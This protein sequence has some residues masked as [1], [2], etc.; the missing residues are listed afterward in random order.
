[1]AIDLNNPDTYQIQDFGGGNTLYRDTSTGQFYDPSDPT[2]PLSTSDVQQYGAPVSIGGA[3]APAGGTASSQSQFGAPAPSTTANS[4]GSGG[5]NLSGMS[6]MFTAIGSAFANM[7]NPPKT[8]PGGQPLVYDSI[9]GT[10]IPASAAG[11]SV[12]N[13]S[14]IPMWVVIGLVLIVGLFIFRKEM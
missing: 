10:Y 4:A 5:I 2:T 3:I 12:T 8:T 9:R 7:I 1:M 6:G 13:I 11:A 14:S